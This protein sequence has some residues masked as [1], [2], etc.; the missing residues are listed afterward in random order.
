MV[1][2]EILV[3]EGS[4]KGTYQEGSFRDGSGGRKV[5]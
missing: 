5:L 1:G 3:E 2:K 4:K